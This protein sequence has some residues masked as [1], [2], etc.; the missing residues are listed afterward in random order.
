MGWYKSLKKKTKGLKKMSR[1]IGGV[2]SG[3]ET[4]TTLDNIEKVVDIGNKISGG[5]EGAIAV[6]AIESKTK[7]RKKGK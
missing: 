5:P 1:D 2:L 3:K 7:Q 4:T 6:S